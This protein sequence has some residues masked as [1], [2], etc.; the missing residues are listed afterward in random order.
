[1]SAD[2]YY[3][4]NVIANRQQLLCDFVDWLGHQGEEGFDLCGVLLVMQDTESEICLKFALWLSQIHSSPP[5]LVVYDGG[6][7]ACL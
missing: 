2:N 4:K 1:M 3:F 7:L 5:Q 6:L